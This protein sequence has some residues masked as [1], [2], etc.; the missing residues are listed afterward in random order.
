M[1]DLNLLEVANNKILLLHIIK[2]SGD[3]FS[4]KEL[5]SFV[6]NNDLLNYFFYKQYI[7]E[8]EDEN[9][10]VL[11]SDNNYKLTEYGSTVLDMFSDK[12]DEDLKEKCNE[13]L[14][15]FKKIKNSEK[16]VYA[17]CNRDEYGR[18]FVELQI[19]EDN[20]VIMNLNMEVPTEEYAIN[21]C[22]NFK[23]KPE[24][25]YLSIIQTID[26]KIKDA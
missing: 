25:L 5:T 6:L 1:D 10:I 12:I 16:S 21:I 20:F 26:K 17:N 15:E 8:L 7:Q 24:E 19:K 4:D 14:L 22:Q 11:N 9:F 3:N 23:E 2:G 18:Y 13:K